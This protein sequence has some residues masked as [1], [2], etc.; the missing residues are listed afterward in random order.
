[1]AAGFDIGIDTAGIG[2][3]GGASS[4][5]QA[6]SFKVVLETTFCGLVLHGF[7]ATGAKGVCRIGATGKV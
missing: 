3:V 5:K 1:M 4:A 2:R 7:N 6:Q